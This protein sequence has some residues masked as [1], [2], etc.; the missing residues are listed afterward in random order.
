MMPKYLSERIRYK[1][2]PFNY[3]KKTFSPKS[4]VLAVQFLHFLMVWG[5]VGEFPNKSYN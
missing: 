2:T 3:L 5:K 1:K 4:E